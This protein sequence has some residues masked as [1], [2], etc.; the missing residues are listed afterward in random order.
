MV[1]WGNATWNQG[2]KTTYNPVVGTSPRRAERSRGHLEGA[3]FTKDKS[4][5][6]PTLT[7]GTSNTLLMAEVIVG[8][9]PRVRRPGP[10]RRRLERRL[11]LCHVPRLLPRPT[12]RSPTGSRGTIAVSVRDEPPVL[13]EEYP[14]FQRLARSFHSGGVNA[15]L[16]DGSVKFFKSSINYTTWCAWAAAQGGEVIDASS[17]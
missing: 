2:L 11:H 7:D 14:R 15:L 5:G 6:I 1:N 3:P 13:R 4:F 12:R 9:D 10:S 8:A 16:A 17:F